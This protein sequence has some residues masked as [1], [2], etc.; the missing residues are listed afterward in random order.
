MKDAVDCWFVEK[1][2]YHNK[3]HFLGF[4]FSSIFLYLVWW[5]LSYDS[6][7]SFWLSKNRGHAWGQNNNVL[8]DFKN[9]I[10]VSDH[11]YRELQALSTWR[12]GLSCCFKLGSCYDVSYRNQLWICVCRME[13]DLLFSQANWFSPFQVNVSSSGFLRNNYSWCFPPNNAKHDPFVP[14]RGRRWR[15]SED[16]TSIQL[17][18]FAGVMSDHPNLLQSQAILAQG[19]SGYQSR[20]SK[21][22]TAFQRLAG[23]FIGAS[24]PTSSAGIGNLNLPSTRNMYVSSTPETWFTC[25]SGR[26]KW[27]WWGPSA[28]L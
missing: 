1:L 8:N 2:S 21:A 10:M 3:A 26:V 23:P 20:S 12:S 6:R 28:N 19:Q 5:S 4:W 24:R 7:F 16:P 22:S 14:Q 27:F 18:D 25:R 9:W 13:H 17:V 11:M 15:R